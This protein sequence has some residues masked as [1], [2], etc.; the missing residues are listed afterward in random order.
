MK[1]AQAQRG[2]TIVEVLVALLI[3]AVLSTVSSTM[4][5]GMLSANQRS[6]QRTSASTVMQ[7]WL[8]RYKANLE[9]LAAA[10]P[11]TTPSATTFK[12]TYSKDWDYGGDGV[13]SHT[14]SMNAKFQGFS[15][16]ITGTQ[17]QVG[18]NRQLWAIT[19][20]VTDPIK[21]QTVEANTYVT[22]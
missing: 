21:N 4:I 5:I 18:A 20:D 10:T 6:R 19:V 16:V 1:G 17:L 7:S 2:M 14:A 12:C 8:E 3:V 22:Q 15:S 13:L 9:P 11:C